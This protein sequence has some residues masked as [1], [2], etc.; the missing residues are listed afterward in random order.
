M[1]DYLSLFKRM[2]QHTAT[3]PEQN[4]YMRMYVGAME[5]QLGKPYFEFTDEEELDYK[6]AE[7][8]SK[9]GNLDLTDGTGYYCAECKNRG[10][11]AV[12]YEGQYAE[13]DCKCVKIR[14]AINQV[15][16]SG[17]GDVF[18]KCTFETFDCKQTWQGLVKD[19]ALEFLKSSANCFYIGGVTGSGKSHICTAIVD[20]F[21]KQGKSIKYM[22]WLDGIDELNNLR[23]RQVDKYDALLNEIK[24]TDVLYIDDFLKG[25]NAV[26]PSAADIKFA[27]RIINSRYVV[28]RSASHK[29]YIT[30]ISSEWALSQIISFDGATGGRISELALRDFVLRIDGTD[31]NQRINFGG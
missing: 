11:F 4:H 29:R 17:L 6:I 14:Q 24:N 19:K 25:D 13:R 21:L 20:H 7:E 16:L 31:K 8:N 1:D 30:V 18:N 2:A 22:Q 26:K 5:K 3:Q 9:E 10:Y 28:S 27:Y 23:F 12:K 15:K